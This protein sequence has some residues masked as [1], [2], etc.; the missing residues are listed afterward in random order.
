M[1]KKNSEIKV[2]LKEASEKASFLH[3]PAKGEC[4]HCGYIATYP[5]IDGKK[6]VTCSKCLQTFEIN[7]DT[8]SIKE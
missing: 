6:V 4:P 8:Q 2:D 1:L 7:D 5:I 3:P